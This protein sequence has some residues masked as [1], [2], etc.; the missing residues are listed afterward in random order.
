MSL[1]RLWSGW[2][3]D[4]VGSAGGSTGTA[5]VFTSILGSGLPDEETFIVHRGTT[6][7]VILNAYPYSTG[8]MLVLPY[9]E[10]ADLEQLTDEESTELW[11]TVT[12]AV[13]AVKRSHRPHALNV[14]INL[15]AS[16]G[17]SISQHLHV[18]VVPR[19]E[20]DANFMT[21]VANTRTLPEPLGETHR[22]I[23]SEW[24]SRTSP[25]EGT[26]R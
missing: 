11:A 6:C 17:G 16:A 10:V 26:G 4:Y 25:Q 3:A 22:L 1:D 7:F 5:S 13:A 12:A 14:G 21:A 15:G 8:H 19:W 20:G 9:R 23:T 18:H 24:N 2:R